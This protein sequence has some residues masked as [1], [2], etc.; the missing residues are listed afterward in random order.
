LP[1]RPGVAVGQNAF[2]AELGGNCLQLR[3]DFIQRS[4]PGN[5][6]EGFHLA[7]L[8]QWAFG[9]AGLSAH[10]VEQALGRVDAVEIAGD[11]AA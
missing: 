5:A 4:I 6:F 2:R 10:G 9:H 8:R 11:F 3:G 1:D 7:A